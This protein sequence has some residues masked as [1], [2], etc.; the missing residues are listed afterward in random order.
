[1]LGVLVSAARRRL[2]HRAPPKRLLHPTRSAV[3]VGRRELLGSCPST[4]VAVD[5]ANWPALANWPTLARGH[6]GL[7]E[8]SVRAPD[9]PGRMETVCTS[10]EFASSTICSRWL[11]P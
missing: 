2:L 8:R 7:D 4:S 11:S 6:Q 1:M 9:K 3:R 5:P 10:G